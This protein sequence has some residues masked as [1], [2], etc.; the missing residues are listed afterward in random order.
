MK[1]WYRQPT[2]LSWYNMM[3]R[4]YNANNP[5][6]DRY[7]GRGIR[8]EER[9]HNFNLFVED[10]GLRP[11]GMTLDRFPNND[12]NYERGNCRWATWKQQNNNRRPRRIK[13]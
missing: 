8:V 4:C 13:K 10:M 11:D 5:A 2:Y 9:W 1:P 6:Y 12:G 7:G 3:S